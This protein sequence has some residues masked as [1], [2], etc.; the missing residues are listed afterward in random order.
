LVIKILT[1]EHILTDDT[2]SL[3]FAGS[4]L[5]S[6]SLT[7]HG[8]AVWVFPASS[9]PTGSGTSPA[10]ESLWRSATSGGRLG[11]TAR[12]PYHLYGSGDYDDDDNEMGSEP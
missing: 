4:R 2:Y 10:L 1:V 8:V 6:G 11:G 12:W 7:I 5:F 3:L 9:G